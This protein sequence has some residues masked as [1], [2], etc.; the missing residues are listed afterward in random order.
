MT[1]TRSILFKS[2]SW[3][4]LAFITLF[5][6]LTLTNSPVQ[7]EKKLICYFIDVGQGDAAL[8]E[9]PNDKTMVIDGGKNDQGS[10]LINFIEKR[11]IK[12][13]DYLIGSHPHT[14]HIGGLDDLIDHFTIGKIFLPKVTHTTKTFEDLLLAVKNKNK[15]ITP[16]RKG[17][18]IIKNA[19]LEISF[20]SP[21]H[22]NYQ[23][24]NNW[25][26]VIKIVYGKTSII[27]T[28][29]IEKEVENELIDSGLN[30]KTD[31]LKISH[32]GSN[33]SSSYNFLEKVSPSLAVISVGADNRYNHPDQKI[34]NLLD[35]LK[36]KVYRTDKQG[37]ITAVSDGKK[38]TINKTA[39]S[40]KK[41]DHI[42][43]DICIESI[44]LQ[45][46]LAIVK[47]KSN[48]PK[49][50]SGWTLLSVKG[51]QKFIFPEATTIRP[52]EILKI[53]S[54]RSAEKDKKTLVWTKAYIWNNNGDKAELYNN[55]S[56]LVDSYK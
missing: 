55:E 20:L 19:N 46:E 29:D 51:E 3:A 12:K 32:H 2:K 25:S 14:D 6:I 35:N 30:L 42:E 56:K 22:N 8:I 18:K 4:Y 27:F 10:Y 21:A 40:A 48:K 16:A 50:I 53:K 54:G 37:T 45:A 13:I 9:L 38:I 1:K 26:A 52:G 41:N 24:L 44:D 49:N 28:G 36:I 7:A 39:I 11:G 5:F 23:K 31:L 43:K 33:S 15:K 34:I 47:N 17:K